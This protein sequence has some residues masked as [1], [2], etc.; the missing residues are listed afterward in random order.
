MMSP[1]VDCDRLVH[2]WLTDLVGETAV[3]SGVPSADPAAE[4][5]NGA[6]PLTIHP[7]AVVPEP[8][9]SVDVHRPR[10]TAVSMRYL[11]CATHPGATSA[12]EH[13]DAVLTWLLDPLARDDDA[14]LIQLDTGVASLD[15]WSTL[16]LPPRPGLVVSARA[17]FSRAARDA[18]PVTTPLRV[19]GAAVTSLTGRLVGPGELPL[20]GAEVSAATTGARARTGTDGSFVLSGVPAGPLTLTIRVKGR[21]FEALADPT[22]EPLLVHCDP[23]EEAQ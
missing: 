7:L 23:T 22:D 8:Q 18:P 13:L 21:T 2:G 6:R 4:P 9:I 20:A 10:A 19:V 17:T 16:G 5:D 15:L 3:R 14:P 1:L 11:I 12:L